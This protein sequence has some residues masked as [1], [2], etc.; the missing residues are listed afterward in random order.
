M[1]FWQTGY[2][3]TIYDGDSEG[4]SA[5]IP[6]RPVEYFCDQCDEVFSQPDALKTH[7]FEAHP[8]RMPCLMKR[9]APLAAIG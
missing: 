6:V 9:G 7:R 1:G 3:D 8:I 2:L 4:M 5:N